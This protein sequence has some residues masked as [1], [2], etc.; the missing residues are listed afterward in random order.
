MKED[1]ACLRKKLKELEENHKH[2]IAELMARCAVEEEGRRRAEEGRRQC[3]Q[4]LAEVEASQWQLE[5]MLTSY[6]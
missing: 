3:A 1:N 2:E 5:G 6:N 4:R